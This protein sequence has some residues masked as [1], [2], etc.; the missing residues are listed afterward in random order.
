MEIRYR[1]ANSW[2]LLSKAGKLAGSAECVPQ[3]E[4]VA[5]PPPVSIESVFAMCVKEVIAGET[6]DEEE[7]GTSSAVLCKSS[8]DMLWL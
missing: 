8:S 3:R 7:A 4:L 5:G 6:A 1:F 2:P